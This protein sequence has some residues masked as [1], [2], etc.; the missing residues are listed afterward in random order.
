VRTLVKNPFR[1]AAV[2]LALTWLLACYPRPHEYTSVPAISGVLI[3]NGMPVSGATVLVAQAGFNSDN[4]CQGLK[5]MG[6]TND[7]GHFN[8]DPVVRLHLLP[9][10]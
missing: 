9:R 3:N 2:G 6:T 10:C 1:L 4:H 8:I 5:A 7:D